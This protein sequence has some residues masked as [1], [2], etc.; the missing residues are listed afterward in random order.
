MYARCWIVEPAGLPLF[1]IRFCMSTSTAVSYRSLF[2]EP[3]RAWFLAATAIGRTPNAMKALACILLV[4]QLTGS[5][6][7]AGIVGA[8]QTLVAALFAPVLARMIDARGANGVLFWTMAAHVIG[9]VALIAAAYSDLHS[10]SMLV[11][12]FIIGAS[13]VQFG[14]LSRAQWVH[15]LGRGRALERAYSLES[16]ID[17]IGFILGPI[18]VVPLCLQVHPT[19]GILTALMLI[20]V[21]SM[22]YMRQPQTNTSTQLSASTLST[23]SSSSKSVMRNP[24]MQ[25]IALALV[26]AGSLFGSVEIVMVAFAEHHG[27][28]NAASFMVASFAGGSLV[29]AIV[30]GAREWPGHIA[31]KLLFSFGWLGLGTIPI[32]LA[33]NV[34][35]MTLVVFITGMAIAPTLITANLFVELISPQKKITEAFAWMGSAAA[36]GVAIGS[37]ATGNLVDEFGIRGGQLSAM[38]GGL[39]AASVIILGWKVFRSQD[40]DR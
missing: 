4:Q 20:I 12:A 37:A 38:S 3:G 40:A 23:D 15:E 1:T 33:P 32:L 30:Y 2:A 18:I 22:M 8:T 29:G 36:A 34:V 16:I 25:L 11:G 7:M 31:A 9:V 39:I 19:A 35:T 21:G 28:A 17:E 6:G 10:A 27:V 24:A 14:S 13:S 26:F 5:Y